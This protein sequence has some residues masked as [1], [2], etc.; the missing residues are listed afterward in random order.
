MALPGLG[1]PDSVL[2]ICGISQ[3]LGAGDLRLFLPLAAWRMRLERTGDR[4]EEEGSEEAFPGPLTGVGA[5]V[6]AGLMGFLQFSKTL[7]YSG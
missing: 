3:G 6:A 5:G 1:L 7:Y 4:A 2:S